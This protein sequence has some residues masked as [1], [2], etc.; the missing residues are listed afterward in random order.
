MPINNAISKSSHSGIDI[1][2]DIGPIF[3]Y[4]LSFIL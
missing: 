3:V 4:R 1:S 2:D